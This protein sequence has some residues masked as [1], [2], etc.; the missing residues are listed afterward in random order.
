MIPQVMAGFP[1]FIQTTRTPPSSLGFLVFV[2]PLPRLAEGRSLH[3]GSR[4]TPT[5]VLV[6]HCLCCAS[7]DIRILKQDIGGNLRHSDYESI[8][9]CVCLMAGIPLLNVVKYDP[10][11]DRVRSSMVEY[12]DM[13]F[14]KLPYTS[15]RPL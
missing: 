15:Q 2:K 6:V 8:I 12:R 13:C 3:L 10:L 9:R 5:L 4:T 14:L 1:C 7:R 11:D